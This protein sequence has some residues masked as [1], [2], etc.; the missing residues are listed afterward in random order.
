MSYKGTLKITIHNKHLIITPLDEGP[1]M[2]KFGNGTM[3]SNFGAMDLMI[4]KEALSVLES[5]LLS[6]DIAKQDPALEIIT[7]DKIWFSGKTALI[8]P[9]DE[10]IH[11]F[12][13]PYHTLC[14]NEVDE[15]IKEFL[16][17][18]K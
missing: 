2:K 8:I 5:K 9:E 15:K 16:D 12:T 4:S 18:Q 1:K 13:I 6:D 7:K 17:G 10:T 14:E 3:V 11:V